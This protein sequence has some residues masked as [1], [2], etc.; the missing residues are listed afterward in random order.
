[1]VATPYA[2]VSHFTFLCSAL[3][4]TWLSPTCDMTHSCEPCHTWACLTSRHTYEWGMPHVCMSESPHPSYA[5]SHVW[6]DSAH[7]TH[8]WGMPHVWMGESY[9]S[10]SPH[11]FCAHWRVRHDSALCVTWLSPMCDMTHSYVSHVIHGSHVTS[12]VW[13]RHAT[14]MNEWV[15]S[16]FSC[17]FTRETKLRPM[18]DMTQSY[19]SHVIH[20]CVSRHV[21]HMHVTC[22]TYEW[23]RHLTLL[24]LI[25][26]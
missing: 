19:V 25:D 12:H 2:W 13:M 11:P 23:V 6:H 1:M 10:E 18:Y 24:V 21:T 7:M 26:V 15:T 5:Y 14:R 20:E 9:I 8:R 3:R 22:H 16:P 17:S 4:V